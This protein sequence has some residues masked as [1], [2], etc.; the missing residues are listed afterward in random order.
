MITIRFEKKNWHVNLTNSC[1]EIQN[2]ICT[3]FLETCSDWIHGTKITQTN[4]SMGR[5][6]TR[7]GG[8]PVLN[9]T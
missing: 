9:L 1:Y 7:Y 6:V 5:R 3:D 2:T 8:S 4:S